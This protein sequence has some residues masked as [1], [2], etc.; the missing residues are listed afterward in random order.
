MKEPEIP[1]SNSNTSTDVLLE[2]L[3]SQPGLRNSSATVSDEVPVDSDIEMPTSSEGQKPIHFQEWEKKLKRFWKQHQV[4]FCP[5]TKNQKQEVKIFQSK[6]LM[7]S[8]HQHLLE[9]HFFQ[10]TVMT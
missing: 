6:R 1:E 8:S 7:N 10:V 2:F 5:F 4:T 3:G 9:I